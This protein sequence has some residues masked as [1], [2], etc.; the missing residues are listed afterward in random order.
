MCHLSSPEK[1]FK[2]AYQ[3]DTYSGVSTFALAPER[4]RNMHGNRGGSM[5]DRA[6]RGLHTLSAPLFLWKHIVQR[7]LGFYT[8]PVK[9]A[10]VRFSCWKL[11]TS[12][13]TVQR[14]DTQRPRVAHREHFVS[15][16]RGETEL[17]DFLL[18][19]LLLL[20]CTKTSLLSSVRPLPV[21]SMQYAFLRPINVS[22]F[23]MTKE[24]FKKC[25]EGFFGEGW[26]GG[27]RGRLRS[28]ARTC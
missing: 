4:I 5:F 24:K 26:G 28:T 16:G 14:A 20:W 22:V 11:S 2:S 8:A 10:C 15:N 19:L 17:E 12:S 1:W 25:S 23:H 9:N 21:V 13:E 27:L 3:R 6:G 18:F 7:G